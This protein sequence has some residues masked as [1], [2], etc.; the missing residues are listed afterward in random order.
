MVR[1]TISRALFFTSIAISRADILAKISAQVPQMHMV[2][3]NEYITTSILIV[4][5]LF[6]FYPSGIGEIF[7]TCV[8][9]KTFG[10]KRLS[11]L[12]K[13]PKAEG[14]RAFTPCPLA[15]TDYG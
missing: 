8:R 5:R 4:T 11:F 7:S 15:I 3:S 1:P 13:K 12:P 2:T 6:L 14:G 9:N 10:Q